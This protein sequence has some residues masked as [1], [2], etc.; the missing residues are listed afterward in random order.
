MFTRENSYRMNR[1]VVWINSVK[2]TSDGL[3]PKRTELG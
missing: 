1:F 3:A 2:T